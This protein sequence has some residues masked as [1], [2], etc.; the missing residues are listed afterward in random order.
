[1][2]REI[3]ETVSGIALIA[4]S[5]GLL[6]VFYFSSSSYNDYFDLLAIILIF[7]TLASMAALVTFSKTGWK[8]TGSKNEW[9]KATILFPGQRLFLGRN[10]NDETKR[11]E[12]RNQKRED[13]YY[14]K[15][16]K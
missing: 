13:Q 7:A 3:K 2:K 8:V 6:A 15:R 14:D 9:D 11:D 10:P 5:V 4:S 16:S 12:I 1:L